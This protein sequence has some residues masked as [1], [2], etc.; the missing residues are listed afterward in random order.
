MVKPLIKTCII[1]LRLGLKF[2]PVF[3]INESV[4][5]FFT[6]AVCLCSG[7]IPQHCCG[8]SYGFLRPGAGRR[9]AEVLSQLRRS[10]TDWQY[11]RGEFQSCSHFIIIN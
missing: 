10:D 9:E 5:T 6:N 7:P 3:Y 4:F 2:A 11:T 1:L 8:E